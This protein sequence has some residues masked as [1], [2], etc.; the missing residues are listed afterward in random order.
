VLPP[1][2]RPQ[3]SGWRN[4][5]AGLRSPS[6]RDPIDGRQ[7]ACVFLPLSPVRM[8]SLRG[9]VHE[10]KRTPRNDL[11][12]RDRDEH[13]R[14]GRGDRRRRRASR[15]FVGV[16][17]GSWSLVAVG[18]VGVV[19]RS[20]FQT[21]VGEV[22]ASLQGPVVSVVDIATPPGFVAAVLFAGATITGHDRHLL[23]P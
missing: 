2:V 22:G 16:G 19:S 4:P 14:R 3:H 5:S 13:A 15:G 20:A 11:A 10:I 9:G 17:F 18:F 1:L 23:R 6:P 12:P 7:V 8:G 21:E